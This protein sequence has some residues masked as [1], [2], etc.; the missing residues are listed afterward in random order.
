VNKLARDTDPGKLFCQDLPKLVAVCIFV[1]PSYSTSTDLAPVKS[2]GRAYIPLVALPLSEGYSARLLGINIVVVILFAPTNAFS[3]TIFNICI[4]QV[5]EPSNITTKPSYLKHRCLHYI[6]IEPVFRHVIIRAKQQCGPA[7]RRVVWWT[8]DQ[9]IIRRIRP[10]YATEQSITAY[11]EQ[12]IWRIWTVYKPEYAA[13]AS[14][15]PS[16]DI[17]PILRFE[18]K[19]TTKPAAATIIRS[20]WRPWTKHTA[21][22]TATATTSWAKSF[23]RT[24]QSAESAAVRRTF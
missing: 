2:P 5:V 13:A 10:E 23:W 24:E 3:S 15:C 16:W 4:F 17:E 14:K 11:A 12:S 19:Y 21:A 18:S 1:S 6:A 22:P 9:T 7:G 20:F 8:A